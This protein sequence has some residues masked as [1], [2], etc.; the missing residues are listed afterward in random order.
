MSK[1]DKQGGSERR[2]TSLRLRSETLKALKIRAIEEDKSVQGL[3][4][5][6]IESYLSEKGRIA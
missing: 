1:D 3:V 2:N 5:E 4:E 6:L